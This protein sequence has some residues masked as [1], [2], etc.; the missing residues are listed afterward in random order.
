VQDHGGQITCANKPEGGALFILRLPAANA[1]P[2]PIAE[3]AKA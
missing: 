1:I 2:Q 3:A